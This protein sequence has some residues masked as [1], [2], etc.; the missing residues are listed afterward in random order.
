V[1]FVAL[2][3]SLVTISTNSKAE[4]VAKDYYAQELK[5]QERID[6]IDNEKKLQKS[7]DLVLQKDSIILSCSMAEIGPD[8]SGEMLFFRPSDSSKDLKLK[9]SFSKIGI[10]SISKNALSR[11]VYKICLSW[12]SN[13]TNYYKEQ[14]IN[15]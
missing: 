12:K 2:I 1:C 14:I 15:I 9:M 7:I 8:F 3:T 4:L 10:Q 5:Y 11:G 13:R 6:A